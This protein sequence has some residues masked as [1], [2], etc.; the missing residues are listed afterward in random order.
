MYS[1]VSCYVPSDRVH[2]IIAIQDNLSKD[3]SCHPGEIHVLNDIL[4]MAGN[5]V[6]YV[7]LIGPLGLFLKIKEGKLSLEK[8]VED[9]EE[10]RRTVLPA[11]RAERGILPTE[12]LPQRRR[13]PQ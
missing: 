5:N 8:I 3:F 11:Q 12:S 13:N 1:P 9:Y 7:F 10:E 6:L 4:S 2:E